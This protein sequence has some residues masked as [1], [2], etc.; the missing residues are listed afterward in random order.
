M[1]P[2]GGVLRNLERDGFLMVG[3]ARWDEEAEVVVVG[4][5]GAGS[6]T[7]ITA[8]DAGAKVLILEK[9][10]ED[11]PGKTNHTPSSR[12]SGGG[13][14]C[15]VDIEKTIAYLEGMVRVSKEPLDAERKEII[16][17][18]AKYLVDN[19]NWMNSIGAQL[20]E[21]AE[22][23]RDGRYMRTGQEAR[24][25]QGK[26]FAADFADLPGADASAIDSLKPIG[27]YR[28][29]AVFFKTLSAAVT[30]RRIPVLWGTP[31]AHLI[32]QRGQVR[33]VVAKRG[34]KQIRVRASRAVVLTC[35]GFEFNEWMKQNYLRAYPAHFYGNPDA[36]GDGIYMAMEIGAALWHMNNASWR[37][38]MKFPEQPVGFSTQLHET[39]SIFIDKRGNRFTN[40]RYKRHSFGYEL[41]NYDCYAMTY[42]KI[43]CYW[44]F[45]E[46]RRVMC[47]LASPQGPCNPPGGIMGDI[48]YVWDEDN[49][50]EIDRGWI[51]KSNTIEG[52]AK[53]IKADPDNSGLLNPS[54]L[55]ATVKRYNEFCRKG[56]DL[57]FHKSREFLQPIE[58]PPYYAVKLWPGG[59]NTQGGPKRNT[60]AQI[61]RVDN[62]PIPRL[63]SA[64]ELG[65]VW[66]MLYQGC[67]NLGECISFGRIAGANAAAE[68]RSG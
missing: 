47:G 14:F 51:M 63:Y 23:L 50:K 30:S 33:G 15:P 46:K 44:L 67:G 12:M 48:F 37:V 18:F 52:L 64:G 10:S 2:D 56:E 32:T 59:P 17:V 60:S 3:Q 31:A 41:T 42:P 66:S 38:N 22:P 16:A 26:L 25:V 11:A 62:T 61:L 27:K 8:H 40:E 13:W 24:F 19:T 35:G 49:R 7:A 21:E 43:P 39:A 6:V 58:D 34:N 5:G 68:K 65:S 57:D 54:N 36:T 55:V 45:D 20:A 1:K 9:Q 53:L 4:Y 28:N 29:G